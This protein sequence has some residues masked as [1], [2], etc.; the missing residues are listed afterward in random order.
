MTA[1]KILEAVAIHANANRFK[2]RE[3][4]NL[5][6]YFVRKFCPWLPLR[7]IANL[8]GIKSHDAVIDSVNQ[9]EQKRVYADFIWSMSEVLKV[10][11]H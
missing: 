2:K 7:Y 1:E 4:K 5:Q 3:V 9:V 11:K 6:R 10:K 8:T